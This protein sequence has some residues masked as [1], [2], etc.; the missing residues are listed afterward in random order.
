MNQHIQLRGIWVVVCGL[1][2]GGMWIFYDQPSGATAHGT[3]ITYT[4][5]S[6]VLINANFDT[7]EPMS[8]AQISVFA[9]DDPENAWLQGVADEN[10][11]FTFVPDPELSGTYDVRIRSAGHGEILAVPVNGAANS[12]AGN[13]TIQQ[14]I[15]A[16][17]VIWGFVGTA[18]Y[19]SARNNKSKN[20]ADSTTEGKLE[21]AHT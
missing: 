2:L 5:Q 15:M 10:G 6:T 14:L 13:S 12:V 20:Q 18:L 1:V 16:A 21:N 3:A 7:G 11:E 8:E 17:A 4:I 9:P 19:F